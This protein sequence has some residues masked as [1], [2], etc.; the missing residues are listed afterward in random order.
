[1]CESGWSNACGIKGIIATL[2]IPT[3]DTQPGRNQYV[4]EPDCSEAAVAV[5]LLHC[6]GQH[7]NNKHIPEF[8]FE[9]GAFPPG[10]RAEFLYEMENKV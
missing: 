5:L 10:R 2:N 3:I 9:F 6:F 1:M 8:V 7:Y 4:D